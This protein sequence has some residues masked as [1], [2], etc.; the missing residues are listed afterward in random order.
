MWRKND[1]TGMK[2]GRWKVIGPAPNHITSGGYP[3]SMWDCVCECGE[4]RAVR[5]NDLRLGKSTSCGCSLIDNPN[6]KKHGETGTPLYMV[7]HGMR[8]RCYNENNKD[9][10]H[11]GGRGIAIC[12]EWQD[13]EKF[14]DWAM[15]NGYQDGLS[16]ER[17]NVNGDYSP[18][19][20]RWANKREQSINKRTT[21]YLTA[22]GET[23]PLVVWA[24]ERKISDAT[25]RRRIKAGWSAD[26]ALSAPVK[27]AAGT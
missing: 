4:K 24:E 11:Y 3:V 2:F 26:R 17:N 16:I 6:S 14:R 1:Y 22:F 19:N 23:K 8:A 5:G 15:L 25:L 10:H 13:Y 27:G 20:C 21:V 18:E 12:D 7:Y 9:Y